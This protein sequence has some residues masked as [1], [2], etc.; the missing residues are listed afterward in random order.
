MIEDLDKQGMERG[1]GKI[2]KSSNFE[3]LVAAGVWHWREDL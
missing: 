1:R 2:A 3:A